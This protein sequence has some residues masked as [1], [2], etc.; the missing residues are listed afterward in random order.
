LRRSSEPVGDSR[1]RNQSSK[2]FVYLGCTRQYSKSN[3]K[4]YSENVRDPYHASAA[5]VRQRF[6]YRTGD[7]ADRAD[8]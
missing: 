6:Q 4:L 5:S 2:P 1:V 3:W 8:K 7:K